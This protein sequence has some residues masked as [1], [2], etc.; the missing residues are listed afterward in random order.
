VPGGVL[1]RWVAGRAPADAADVPER[2]RIT[3][4]D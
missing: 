4:S 2:D 1:A 3:R